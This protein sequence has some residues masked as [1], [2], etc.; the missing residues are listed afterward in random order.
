VLGCY[1]GERIY[2]YRV[3][4][5]RLAGTNEVT[6]AHEMLHAAYSRLSSSDRVALDVLIKDF[7]A[8]LPADD[9]TVELVDGYPPEQRRDEWHSRLGTEYAALTP[10]LEEHY[11]QYF[12]DRSAVVALNEESTHRLRELEDRIS[13]LVARIDELGARIDDES[14]DYD[15][16][17]DGL[18]ADID[19]FN[20]RADSGWFTSQAQFDAERARLVARSDALEEDRK[21]L[22]DDVEEYNALVAQL[23]ELDADYSDLY[24]S[25]DST[26]PPEGIDG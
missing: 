7:V 25:L 16:R 11:A 22:N 21:A 18:N 17:L 3:T 23:E 4:D 5:E 14:S 24:S 26:A 10:E 15:R 20:R 12:D 19:D 6:A 1:D 13:G 2:V 9:P 8:T